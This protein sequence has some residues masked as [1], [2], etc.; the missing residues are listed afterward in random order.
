MN[1]IN[2]TVI[3]GQSQVINL[4]YRDWSNP[5]NVRTKAGATYTR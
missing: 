5:V 2:T 1:V 4:L 3:A